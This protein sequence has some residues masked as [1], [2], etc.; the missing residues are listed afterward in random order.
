MIIIYP[1]YHI[2]N[3]L[4]QVGFYI[5]RVCFYNPFNKDKAQNIAMH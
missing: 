2:E 4:K 1:V 3:P 5:I